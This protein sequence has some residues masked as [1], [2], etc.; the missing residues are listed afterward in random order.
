MTGLIDAA[1]SH[2]RTVLSIL[3][4]ATIWGIASYVNIPKE[5]DPDI[6]FP[7]IL[8]EIPHPGISPVDA[9]RL[10]IKPM[11]K[12]LQSIDGVTELNAKAFEGMAFL[13]LEFEVD[14]DADQ[15]LIDVREE[16]DI[17]KTDLPDDT[18]E[19][20]VSE[21]NASLFPVIT[22]TLS[23]DI[24]ER[25]LHELSRKLKDKLDALPSVLNAKI[26]GD[27]EELLEVVVEP[28][29]L[30][31]YNVSQ[32][33]LINA[34][35]MNNRLVAAGALDSGQGR[36]SV[37]VPGLVETAQDVY[38]M[39]IKV[40]G[41][42]VVTLSDLAEIRRTFKDAEGYARFNGKPS[43]ALQIV[44]RL[45][46][47]M[48]ETSESV[49]ET[50]LQ[51][52]RFWPEGVE[53]GFILDQSTF[54]KDALGQL[55]A[56]ILT[57]ISLVMI[58]IVAA[59]GVRSGFM[60]G[61]AIPTSFLL[62]FLVLNEIGFT[63]NIIVMF[64]LVL[65]VGML[66]DGAIVIV[67]YADRKMAEGIDRSVAYGLAAKRMFWPIISSTATTLAAF[68]PMVLWPG[69][70]GKFM[71]YLPYTLMIILTASLVVALICL[72][73]LG[74]IFG[75]SQKLDS[76]ELKALAMGE[77][78]PLEDIGGYTGRY[79]RLVTK[80][81]HHPFR[82]LG[83][84]VLIVTAIA[85][86]FLRF[87]V[88]TVFF[89]DGDPEFAAVIVGGRG[90]LSTEEK[91]DLAI[92][93]ENVIAQIPG[94]KA[95][96]TTIGGVAEIAA[97]PETPPPDDMIARINVE[98]K[99]WQQRQMTGKE[100]I[101]EIRLR[102]DGFPG[103]RIE[104]RREEDG[105]PVGK[106]IQ[107]ELRSDDGDILMAETARIR[108]FMDTLDGLIELEDSRP[109]PGIQWE[110]YVDREQAGKFGADITQVGVMVQ[111]VTNGVLLGEYRPD[112]AEDEVEIRVRYPYE[113]RSINQLDRLRV[114]TADGLIPIS[115]FV[116][117]TPRPQVN[118]IDRRDGQR[119]M[120]VRSNVAPDVV[121]AD[122]VK[123]I[124]A[125]LTKAEI[126][127]R[128]FYN[129]R[130]ADEES[131]AAAEF[132]QGAMLL[133]LF[134]M[135]IILL[136]Q[137]NSFYHVVLT[138]SSVAISTVGVLL[139]IMI[140][141]QSFS[142]VMTGTGI[143]ALAGIVVNNNIVLIDTYHRL[144]DSGYDLYDAVIRTSAQR[145]RPVLLTT[146]TTICGLLPMALQVN[147]D[148]FGR[149]ISVGGPISLWWV[150][151]A[152]AVIFG[153]AFA[154]LVTLVLTPSL[155]V[156]PD[157]LKKMP[158]LAKIAPTQKTIQPAE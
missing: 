127:P 98:F 10:L 74:S 64:G 104:V 92:G 124:E 111:L 144:R 16:V 20:V 140:T 153:L 136:T 58:I 117:R 93:V 108:A 107:L 103:L 48:I 17:A 126:D 109:L 31:T 2:T 134:L 123:V 6:P 138:L 94:V 114:Q 45:G 68:L 73:V 113:Y 141:G 129:F 75:K 50:V 13:A 79:V 76:R 21:M 149:D 47:N 61:L 90:N 56:A 14:F 37:K 24:P 155:L 62:G 59:L 157:H 38:D 12:R 131:E 60:V 5:S 102:L 36:F 67:E 80:A 35:T 125:W 54:I 88:G 143:V 100:L 71:S 29:K 57:A 112:D 148:Y 40:S 19:P 142:M 139:G 69:L 34:V 44:K 70:T 106:D 32:Q 150:E 46:S 84:S 18:E 147:L 43:I 28:S 130:G 7:F 120:F 91:R 27:R 137:F 41:D 22:V 30:E 52:S 11:E 96:A 145:L 118:K 154:T 110:L 51:E 146:I 152:T 101:N 26:T 8:V 42:G 105:P 23:G 3:L 55:Q 33:E 15:A 53:V 115:N 85:L 95:I 81:V 39:P 97:G 133:S 121:I 1:L 151:L 119:V 83:L 9:E 135:G 99:P 122:K 156:L 87:N 72:P 77:S 82:V 116:T 158:W 128:V 86:S 89:I 63:V 65:S 78:G 132:L 66:V 25:K 49:R 4:I